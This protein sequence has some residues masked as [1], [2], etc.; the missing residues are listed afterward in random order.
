[1]RRNMSLSLALGLLLAGGAARADV[2]DIQS[3]ND[4]SAGTDNELVHGT[5]QRHDL[6]TLPGPTPDQDWYRVGQKPQSSYEV[7]VDSTSGDIGFPLLVQRMAPGGTTVL[8][9]S[10]SISPG[11]DYSRSLRWENTTPNT[12]NGEYIRV[13]SGSCTTN[14]GPDDV[15]D[16]RFRETTIAVPRFNNQGGQVTVLIIQNAGSTSATGTMWFRNTAGMGVAASSVGTI[17]AGGAL[18]LNTAGLA[19]GLSGTI[20]ISHNARY[21]DLAVKSVALEPATGFSFDTPGLYRP[22]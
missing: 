2:W 22:F 18:V 10:V 19:P 16:I 6:G 20:T 5:A 9:D 3:D 17:A 12:V 11:L 15:Y 21:G 1:M 4:N 13:I 8:Q 14:C 7:I